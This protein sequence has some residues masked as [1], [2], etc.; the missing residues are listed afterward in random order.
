MQYL[1]D[2]LRNIL[3]LMRSLLWRMIVPLLFLGIGW[4]AGGKYGAPDL[5]IRAVD[6]G[7]YRAKV[8][9][10][11]LISRGVEEGG[12]ARSL[13]GAW[14]FVEAWPFLRGAP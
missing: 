13:V 7:A 6:G 5:L 10:S 3:G 4:Y 14:P 9:L 11:P 12:K 1:F 2:I 8:I